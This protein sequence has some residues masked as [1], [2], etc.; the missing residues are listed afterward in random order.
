MTKY[1]KNAYHSLNME[2]FPHPGNFYA[3]FI[4]SISTF[5]FVC[6]GLHLCQKDK[7]RLQGIVGLSFE[8]IGKTLRFIEDLNTQQVL[9]KAEKLWITPHMFSC[10]LKL[11][12]WI[13]CI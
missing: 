9:K 6:V 3:S 12:F 13:T 7:N 4:A 8:S 11:V 1:N 5:S 10:H 2:E